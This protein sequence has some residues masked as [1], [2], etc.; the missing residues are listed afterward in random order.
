MFDF[1]VIVVGAGPAGSVAAKT[2]ASAGLKT[3]L[4][5]KRQEIG[6]PV[7]C[8]EATVTREEIEK[9][10]PISEN[11]I[12][13][14]ILT[15]KI[16]S[17]SGKEAHKKK[18]SK[19]G[20]IV[21]RKIFDRALAEQAASFG[22]EIYCRYTVVGLTEN[23]V[24]VNSFGKEFELTG[25]YIVAADG[26]ESQVARFAG[27]NNSLKL[28]ELYP[29]IQYLVK[30][31]EIENGCPEIHVGN[32]IAPGGYVWVFPKGEKIANI[33][34]GISANKSKD[35][36]AKAYLD[37]FM[38]RKFPKGKII[39]MI[40]GGVPTSSYT[41]NLI[42]KNILFVGDAAR[43]V[44]PLTGGGIF[45]ALNSGKYAGEAIIEAFT[46]NDNSL[47]QNY[48]KRWDADFGKTFAN[49]SKLRDIFIQTNDKELDFLVEAANQV[50]KETENETNFNSVIIDTLFKIFSKHPKFLLKAGL[51]FLKGS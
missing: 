39:G 1:D 19:I 44:N 8:G 37:E 2:T 34:I 49:Y 5:E 50:L 18:A 25:R 46:K 38:G 32:Q 31:I 4:L 36:N 3:I 12:N 13:S 11:W 16:I 23:G 9:F 10:I 33:G 45:F 30:D 22:S 35:K 21:E 7:R 47:L 20:L 15:A 43:Q 48:Q 42:H 26:I 27:I 28:K 41:K 29:C 24:K 17:P 40:L 14:E 51:S 6:T